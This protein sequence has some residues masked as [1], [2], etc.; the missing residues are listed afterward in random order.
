MNKN[1]RYKPL[2]LLMSE[3]KNEPKK[4]LLPSLTVYIQILIHFYGLT[5]RKKK[6]LELALLYYA[7][8]IE[9]LEKGIINY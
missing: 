3:W 2:F 1:Q 5:W 4:I 8:W 9:Y 6:L 7:D